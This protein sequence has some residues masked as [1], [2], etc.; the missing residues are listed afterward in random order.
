MGFP[1]CSTHSL[2]KILNWL[3]Q[4][5]HLHHQLLFSDCWVQ[6]SVPSSHLTVWSYHHPSKSLTRVQRCQELGRREVCGSSRQPFHSTRDWR[7]FFE[8]LLLNPA[9]VIK[10]LLWRKAEEE[11]V[12]R[13]LWP[14]QTQ[15]ESTVRRGNAFP[16]AS[17][18]LLT[19]RCGGKWNSSLLYWKIQVFKFA[20]I[21]WQQ[22]D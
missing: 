9:W 10:G 14:L 5:A 2:T 16:P 8:F 1:A 3:S 18:V 7:N 11:R 21:D 6:C 22:K 13:L 15:L 20:K 12:E 19:W 17:L 4:K